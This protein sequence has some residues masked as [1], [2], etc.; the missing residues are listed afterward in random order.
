M[1]RTVAAIIFVAFLA[2]P[3]V[4]ADE[5]EVLTNEDILVM[6]EA[7]L[8]ERVIVAKILASDADFDT[9]REQ[10]VALSQAGVRTAVL[11]AMVVKSVPSPTQQ[12]PRT[13]AQRFEG[14]PCTASGLFVEKEGALRPVNPQI[15]QIQSGN[16]V[17]TAVTWGMFAGR[18]KAAIRGASSDTRTSNRM[19]VFWFCPEDSLVTANSG[20]TVDPREF[21][22]VVLKASENR[23]ERSFPVGRASVWA[24]GKSDIPPR[25][26]RR[27]KYENV[28]FGVY[29]MTPRSALDPGEYGFYY[30]GRRSAATGL[31][32]TGKIYAFG[33]DKA[34]DTR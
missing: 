32:G 21:L 7:G 15:P 28:G 29:R 33:V 10:L 3:A 13:Y 11:E 26:I 23:K 9:T 25:L 20:T 34:R 4:V 14:T 24:G 1:N 17:L 18:A 19:P 12:A 30:T 5:E 22:L 27:V 2:Q 31:P 8:A 16:N 6:T